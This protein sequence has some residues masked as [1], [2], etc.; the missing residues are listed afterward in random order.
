MVTYETSAFCPADDRALSPAPSITAVPSAEA[1]APPGIPP[2][3]LACVEICN[4]RRLARTR[5]EL[6]EATTILVGANNSGKTS[7]LTVL[8]N[9]LSESP[10]FRAFDISLSRWAK[11][12]ELSELWEALDED[13]TTDLKDVERWE[14]QYRQL[15]ACMPFIDL[16]FDA[17]EGGY[18]HVAPFITSLKWPGG[19]VGVRVRLEPVEDATQLRMLAWRY[20]EARAPVRNLP[21]D[22]HAWPMTCLTTGSGTPRTYAVS[23]LTDSTPPR[24]PSEIQSIVTFRSCRLAPSRSSCNSCASSSAWILCRLNGGLV[25]KKTKLGQN[26]RA[27]VLGCS[28][29]SF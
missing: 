26:R 4:F 6:D 29:A 5:L 27:R 9:F 3:R 12:R 13:P 28:R 16:W 23:R 10:G 2:I 7:I 15:L 14:E 24:G 8:R 17:R 22:G 11:L 19:A 1:A 18:N 20:R 25:P 21:K